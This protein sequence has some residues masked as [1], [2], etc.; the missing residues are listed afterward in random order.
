MQPAEIVAIAV[1]VV[2]LFTAVLGGLAWLIKA[3]TAMQ[4]QF[5]PNGGESAH[6]YLAEIRK[7]VRE[8]R[9]KIDDHIDWHM[10]QR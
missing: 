8:I 2:T 10:D 1:G 9:V 6:D 5:K 7:D 3:Q 4:R